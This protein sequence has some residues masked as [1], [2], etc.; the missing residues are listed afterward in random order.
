MR[1][2]AINYLTSGYNPNMH[3]I[4]FILGFTACLILLL[5]LR[6]LAVFGPWAKA[7]CSGAGVPLGAIVGM[8]LRGTNT[9]LMI[10]AYSRLKI[11][12]KKV[13]LEKLETIYI[14]N[15]DRIRSAEDLIDMAMQ[16]AE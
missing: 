8:R 1:L 10:D 6:I 7:L 14:T 12:N 2:S 9:R 5:I 13:S 3:V 11:R 15:K 4:S 16:D